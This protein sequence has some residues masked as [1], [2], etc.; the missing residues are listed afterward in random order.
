[1]PT[2]LYTIEGLN[3]TCPHCGK[4]DAMVRR[5]E[6]NE[7]TGAVGVVYTCF[8]CGCCVLS[9]EITLMTGEQFMERALDK[10]EGTA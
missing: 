1:M 10:K 2:T 7:V 9:P 6:E 8:Y 5:Y 4:W 3:P